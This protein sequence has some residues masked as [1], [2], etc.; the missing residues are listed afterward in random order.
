MHKKC[1][2]ISG[3]LKRNPSFKCAHCLGTARPVYGRKM[4]EVQMGNDKLEVVTDFCYLG[5]MISAERGRELS[6]ITRCK[7]AWSKFRQLLSL[8]TNPHLLFT[9]RG[10]IYNTYIRAVML[11]SSE[12]WSLTTPSLNRLKRNDSARIRWICK[13]RVE[14][15]ISAEKLHAKLGIQ[16]IESALRCHRLRWFGHV[17]RSSDWLSKVREFKVVGV[18]KPGRPKMTWK[19]L[20][21]K[22]RTKLNLME[23]DPYDRLTWKRLQKSLTLC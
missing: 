9:T 10:Q 11:Y 17:V 7:S 22:D 6:S 5:D 2:G 3:G 19:E 23:I 4:T 8:L 13:A 1:C 14:D 21:I 12:T 16:N 20:L 15:R 18:K